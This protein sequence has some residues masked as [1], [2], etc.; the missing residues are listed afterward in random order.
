M[1]KKKGEEKG[2][3]NEKGKEGVRGD[4]KGEK[5]KNVVKVQKKRGRKGD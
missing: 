1:Q 3:N 5:G 4:Y 2:L